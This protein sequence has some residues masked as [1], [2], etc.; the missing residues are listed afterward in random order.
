ME[1]RRLGNS[2]LK[3]ARICL[4]T[5]Q[6]GWT[7]DEKA[8]F[9]VM[10]AYVEAGG[11]FIDTADVYSAWVEGNPGG[12]SEEIIGRWLKA[13][14]NRH[15]MVVATKFNGRMWPG[16]NGDGLSRGHVMKAID[17]SLR[18]LQTDY[19]DL[20]QTHWPHYDTPQEETLRALDD[21]VK[22]GKVRYIGC[23]NEPAWR[24]VKAMWIS[25]KYN[26]NRFISLQPPYSLVRRADFERELEAVCLDQG[27]GVIPYSPLQGG[28]LTGK[29]RRGQIAESARAE[30]LKRYFTEKNFD[31]IEL[32][33]QIGKRH[34]ATVTQV[35]LAW[36]L[37][38]P[39]IT[40]PI[41][42]ANNVA[43]L[44]DILGSLEVKLSEED[45]K[46]IDAASD[47]RE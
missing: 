7:A 34:G 44:K 1:Y 43:Q 10:D 2:G 28:F 16:P 8:A 37:Q 20:Y 26:L 33:D 23:S 9:E 45:V 14:G 29:Y 3:V 5:M 22:A 40:S 13:R 25:D 15:L 11:N 4:G 39:A 36:M 24:L 12:V 35:A 32:L 17:D 19:I 38:R 6:F 30:G 46:A 42:G 18:R 41:I 31:L 47:W 21:L 27:I